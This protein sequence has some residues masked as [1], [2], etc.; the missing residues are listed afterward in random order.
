MLESRTSRNPH[1]AHSLHEELRALATRAR[2]ADAVVI[3]A[4]SPVVWGSAI[5]RIPYGDVVRTPELEEALRYLDMSRH[6]LVQAVPR[7][8]SEPPGAP[9]DVTAVVENAGPTTGLDADARRELTRAALR[10]V[11]QLP[12]IE[13]LKRGKAFRDVRRTDEA[14]YVVHSFAAIYLA[15]LVFEGPFDELR[16]QRAMADALPRVERLV[17]ALPPFDPEPEPMADVINIRRSRRR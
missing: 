1:P 17:L 7:A 11:R 9:Q 10:M 5:D 14:N 4:H 6:E 12:E 16:A 13:S 15:M 2:A 8:G 3:D